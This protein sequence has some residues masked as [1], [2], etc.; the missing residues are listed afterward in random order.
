MSRWLGSNDEE[1]CLAD[2][3]AGLRGA[4]YSAAAPGWIWVA[5]LFFPSLTLLFLGILTSALDQEFDA[6]GTIV[7]QP[8]L[9]LIAINPLLLFPLRLQAGLAILMQ[10]GALAGLPARGR[11]TPRLTE[12]WRASEGL[13]WPV[14]FLW[15]RLTLVLLV[16]LSL[17][18]VPPWFFLKGIGIMPHSVQFLLLMSPFFALATLF[19]V[20]IA[21]LYHLALQSLVRHRRG[22]S[23]ALT[24]AWR[25]AAHRPWAT[26][27]V[28]LIDLL[29]TV[30]VV[31]V[32]YTLTAVLALSIVGIVAILPL[33]LLVMPGVEGNARAGYWARMYSA[34]GGLPGG[35]PGGTRS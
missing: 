28:M 31:I 2:A 12:C 11:R 20:T 23:S 32:G 8:W 9:S 7:W 10:P 26:F 27:R 29:L 4:A 30:V 13:L 18:V 25:I 17:V 15:L 21:S 3:A 34:L 14:F 33:V 1:L 24:H 16:G 22:A 5:G 19:Q 6:P 35:L